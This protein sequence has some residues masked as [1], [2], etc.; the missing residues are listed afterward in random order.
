[1]CY[2]PLAARGTAHLLGAKGE[3][4]R[5]SVSVCLVFCFVL[6]RDALTCRRE[7]R[8]LR[9]S[10]GRNNPHKNATGLTEN[11]KER[12][13]TRPTCQK[14]PRKRKDPL[15]RI[16]SPGSVIV[17]LNNKSPRSSGR[18]AAL[19]VAVV[20]V[21]GVVRPRSR[22]KESSGRPPDGRRAKG[23][24]ILLVHDGQNTQKAGKLRKNWRAVETHATAYADLILAV[25][26]AYFIGNPASSPSPRTWS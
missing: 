20:A 24:P 25:R 3:P 10:N 23:W 26:S 2:R 9:S 17:S 15:I 12:I 13:D 1:M 7:E 5:D 4:R 21:G 6:N 22:S 16:D 8:E 19:L 14:R 18:R 11:Y